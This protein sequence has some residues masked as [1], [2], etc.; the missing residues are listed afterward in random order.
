MAKGKEAR[1]QR[2]LTPLDVHKIAS[3][4]K[5]FKD[6]LDPSVAACS[7]TNRNVRMDNFVALRASYQI[8]LIRVRP[9]I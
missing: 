6:P 1:R 7:Q 3:C 8:R 5:A 2:P 9:L 4:G